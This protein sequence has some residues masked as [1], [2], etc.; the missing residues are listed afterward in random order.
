MWVNLDG[1]LGGEWSAVSLWLCSV[2]ACP[3][4]IEWGQ[5]MLPECGLAA[6]PHG[7]GCS[8]GTERGKRENLPHL[9]FLAAMY[10]QIRFSV[11]FHHG[12]HLTTA[13]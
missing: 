5:K 11:P 4:K 10:K 6:P 3:E 8:D 7:L 9:C 12:A 1:Q 2:M 13:S